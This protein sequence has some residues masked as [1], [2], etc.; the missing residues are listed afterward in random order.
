MNPHTFTEALTRLSQSALGIK[1]ATVLFNIAVGYDNNQKLAEITASVPT[2]ILSRTGI[3]RRK[4]LI[5]RE[6]NAG[7]RM[8]HILTPKAD[9][10]LKTVIPDE[11]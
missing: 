8:C 4:G 7:G 6:W 10:L 11:P 9:K 3:L 1:E 2:H 5:K